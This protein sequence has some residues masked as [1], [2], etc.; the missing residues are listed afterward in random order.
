MGDV[1]D[2]VALFI[3]M[4]TEAM[5]KGQIEVAMW[6]VVEAHDTLARTVGKPTILNTGKRWT[7]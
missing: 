4:A 2:R 3:V 6:L 7:Q 5:R 1:F